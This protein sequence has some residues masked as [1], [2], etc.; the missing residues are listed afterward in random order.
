MSLELHVARLYDQQLRFQAAQYSNMGSGRADSAAYLDGLFHRLVGLAAPTLSVEAGAYRADASRRVRADHPDCRTVAFEANTYN[1]RAVSQ[2]HDF[3]AAGIEYLNLAVT[4]EPGEVT[5]HLRSSAG[6]EDLR[7]VTGNSSLLKRLDPTTTYEPMTVPAV[8]LDSFFAD[9]DPATTRSV[10]WI[11]VEGA[12]GPLLRGASTFLRSCDVVMIE[13]EEKAMWEEQWL[14]LDVLSF[15]IGRDFVP[16]ARDIEYE[17]QFN[18]VLASA[19][20]ARRPEVLMA[21]ELHENFLVH[22]MGRS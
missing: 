2:E 5:F 21:L 17:N 11:D 12:S 19:E 13:V 7:Q 6:G 14:S 16:L 9:V 10:L 22:H 18:L 4:E 15:L 3:A 1:F 8:S 20:F